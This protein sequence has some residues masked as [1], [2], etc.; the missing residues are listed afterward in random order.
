MIRDSAL[1]NPTTIIETC[2]MAD[3]LKFPITSDS[4]SECFSLKLENTQD[5]SRKTPRLAS[6]SD[7]GSA[8]RSRFNVSR[9]AGI[10]TGPL[11]MHISGGDSEFDQ[12]TYRSID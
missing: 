12:I 9:D 4:F 7:S 5:G 3:I 10:S 8:F 2:S 11:R 1:W 6:D